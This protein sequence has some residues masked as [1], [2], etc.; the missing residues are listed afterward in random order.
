MSAPAGAASAW[1]HTWPK[2]PTCHPS[3]LVCCS[4]VESSYFTPL[5]RMT[6]S[7]Y[8]PASPLITAPHWGQGSGTIS[9]KGGTI[10]DQMIGP[11]AISPSLANCEKNRFQEVASNKGRTPKICSATL[12]CASQLSTSECVD[13]MG[14]FDRGNNSGKHM[15]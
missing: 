14:T 8:A 12:E 9:P 2:I 5:L 13:A 3:R 11:N 7:T 1:R 6:V 15:Y 10:S 4:V